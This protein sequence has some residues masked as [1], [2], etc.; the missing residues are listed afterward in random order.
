MESCTNI[1]VKMVHAVL[2]VREIET[3]YIIILCNN[4]TSKDFIIDQFGTSTI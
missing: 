1:N 3:L 4:K 2:K